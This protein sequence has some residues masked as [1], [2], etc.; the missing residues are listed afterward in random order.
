[1]K[2]SDVL[3][4][5]RSLSGSLQRLR[6][7]LAWVELIRT[8]KRPH[9]PP[10]FQISHDLESEI[11]NEYGYFIKT[12]MD[13]HDVLNKVPKKN[14]EPLQRRLMKIEGKMHR[15]NLPAGL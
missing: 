5:L 14:R 7:L 8:E 12:A 15:L 2:E 6:A 3:R 11:R 1:M 13:I 4:G 9:Q 10:A